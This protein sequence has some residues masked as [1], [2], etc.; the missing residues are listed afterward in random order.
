MDKLINASLYAYLIDKSHDA[1][2]I[3][4]NVLARINSERPVEE[5][6]QYYITAYR[7]LQEHGTQILRHWKD[8]EEFVNNNDE[9]GYLAYEKEHRKEYYPRA[10]PWN[11][12]TEAQHKQMFYNFTKGTGY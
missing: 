5:T 6:L 3:Y 10:S 7:E 2:M 8:I 4:S 9:A 11:D 1:N 12:D